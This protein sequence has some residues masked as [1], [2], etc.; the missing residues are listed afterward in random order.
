MIVRVDADTVTSVAVESTGQ[1][2]DKAVALTI[3]QLFDYVQQLL[4]TEDYKVS[5]A[6]QPDLGYPSLIDY[7]CEPSGLDCGERRSIQLVA[8]PLA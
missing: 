6:F 2:V 7:S 4:N 5:L 8:Q 3:P 1:L